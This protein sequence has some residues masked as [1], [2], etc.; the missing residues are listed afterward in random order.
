MPESLL[1][2]GFTEIRAQIT[3]ALHGGRG[4][5]H[6]L[7]QSEKDNILSVIR[8]GE[9]RFYY[10]Q[11]VDPALSHQWS[12]LYPLLT[13]PIQADI[14]DYELPDDYGGIVG[15][16]TY[17]AEDNTPSP[18]IKVPEYHILQQRGRSTNTSGFPRYFAERSVVSDGLR[19]QRWMI[20]FWPTPDGDYTLLGK[21]RVHPGGMSENRPYPY[22]GVE[23]SQTILESCLAAAEQQ[24]GE[25]GIHTRAFLN[26]LSA[27]IQYDRA[28][29][30]PDFH[31]YNGD[32]GALRF[33]GQ[34]VR[35][36]IATVGGVEY[37]G[38]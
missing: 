18:V 38:S 10:P 17:A 14:D 5:Y 26:A 37:T 33:R 7:E 27:S 34:R 20:R 1:Q 12:F 13:L 9:R 36:G 21:Y 19:A 23:H 3:Q 31:G 28:N 22:G 15:S 32:S 2:I 11:V 29:R 30:T 6:N 24:N 4:E 35:E 16:L 8:T 25:E